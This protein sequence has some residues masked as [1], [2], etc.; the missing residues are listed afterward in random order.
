MTQTIES[1]YN[2]HIETGD[3]NMWNAWASY[4]V[5]GVT[6]HALIEANGR[7]SWKTKRTALKHAREYK[8]THL[9]D[10]WVAEEF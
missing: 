10:S 8:S 2:Y 6:H 7:T 4:E 3:V 5:D 9:R 1:V